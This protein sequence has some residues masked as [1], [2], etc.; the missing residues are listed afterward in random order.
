VELYLHHPIHLH[1]VVPRQTQGQLYLFL[2]HN[3]PTSPILSI[4]SE[5]VNRSNVNYILGYTSH[6]VVIPTEPSFSYGL[7]FT[8][9]CVAAS[10]LQVYFVPP[11]QYSSP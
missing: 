4:I 1:G 8:A 3:E 5:V 9:L 2:V 6:N 11:T 10:C 7:Y